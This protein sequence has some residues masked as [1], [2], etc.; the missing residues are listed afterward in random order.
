MTLLLI[1]SNKSSFLL[2][3]LM[4]ILIDGEE[5]AKYTYK[6]LEEF[7]VDIEGRIRKEV[8]LE[9][10]KHNYSEDVYQESCLHS[11]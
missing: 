11:L 6:E 5:M 9:I 7:K 4:N 10:R 8:F 1:N 2:V 3:C